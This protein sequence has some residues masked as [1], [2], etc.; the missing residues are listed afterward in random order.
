[1]SATGIDQARPDNVAVAGTPRL[2]AVALTESAIRLPGPSCKQRLFARPC[3]ARAY[4]PPRT[5]RSVRHVRGI[6]TGGPEAEAQPPRRP[7]LQLRPR[8]GQRRRDHDPSPRLGR[9]KAAELL[10]HAPGKAV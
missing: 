4:A 3:V 10:I 5:R 2:S 7:V 9:R 6:E 8:Y 1:M